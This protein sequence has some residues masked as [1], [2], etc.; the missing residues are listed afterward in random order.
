MFKIICFHRVSNEISPAYQPIPVTVFDK[1]INYLTRNYFVVP[2]ND[3][4]CLN[5]TRKKKLV[6]TF[7]DAYYD[8]YENAL[9]VLIKYGVSSVQHVITKCADTGES[10][11]TQKL[12]KVIESYYLTQS[13][14]VISDIEFEECPKNYKEVQFVALTLYLKLL[15][16]SKRDE[17]INR[18]IAEAKSEIEFTKMMNWSEIKDCT[19]NKVLIGSHTHSHVNLSNIDYLSQDYEL[20]ESRRKI[21]EQVSL[22]VSLAF[23]NGKYNS[24]TIDVAC[25]HGYEFMFTTEKSHLI[26]NNAKNVFTRYSLYHYEWWKNYLMLTHNKYL[27]K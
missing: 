9:P 24:E 1:I 17:I 3:I 19:A 18:L 23:P 10:F 25:K 21:L 12:N 11:W 14:I 6:I 26:E 8:F 20:G 27:E 22:C 5:T 16:I 13:K 4:D 7:D 15:N 2:L